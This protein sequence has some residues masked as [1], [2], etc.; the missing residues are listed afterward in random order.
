MKQKISTP[1]AIVIVLVVA[2]I[3]L[4]GLYQKY[5]VQ[6]TYSVQDIAGKFK[7]AGAKSQ[8]PPNMQP[9]QGG[10]QQ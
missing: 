10:K 3:L 7:A 8:A 4:G 9:Q 5:M 2:A 6:P 1:V